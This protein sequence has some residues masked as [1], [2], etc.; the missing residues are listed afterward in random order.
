[1]L[2][3]L[4]SS[5][6]YTKGQFPFQR[7]SSKSSAEYFRERERERV[8][9]CV[10]SPLVTLNFIYWGRASESLGL[11]DISLPQISQAQR[12]SSKLCDLR[13]D[14][15]G[16]L[17][18]LLCGSTQKPQRSNLAHSDFCGPRSIPVLPCRLQPK[19]PVSFFESHRLT[20]VLTVRFAVLYALNLLVCLSGK[21]LCF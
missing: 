8:D 21:C 3:Q 4:F 12:C 9:M 11:P 13:W 14:T 20:L 2:H 1:M 6:F 15:C 16:Y 5:Y 18:L 19:A 7:N 10:E 17:Q